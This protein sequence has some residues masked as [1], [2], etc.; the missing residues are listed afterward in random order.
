MNYELHLYVATVKNLRGVIFSVSKD[1]I[2]ERGLKWLA[3]HFKYR[4]LGIAPSM[5]KR[6]EFLNKYLTRKQFITLRYP[7]QGVKRIAENLQVILNT[8]RIL[9][10]TICL[11][12]AYISPLIVI[13]KDSVKVLERFTILKVLGKEKMTTSDIKF[14]LRVADYSVLDMYVWSIENAREVLESISKG[15]EYEEYLKY[16]LKRVA[17]DSKRFWRITQ[18]HKV[19]IVMY[20][21]L[22][23]SLIGSCNLKLIK[24]YI[25]LWTGTELLVFAIIPGFLLP[26]EVCRQGR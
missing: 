11:S 15:E 10:E 2:L 3:R 16:R 4:N 22:L 12:S 25:K 14:H 24:K 19:C 9:I 7:T 26:L 13:G 21:D 23:N 18:E 1:D 6:Y 20:V 8:K 5:I 17:D